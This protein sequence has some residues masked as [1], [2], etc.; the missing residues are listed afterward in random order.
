MAN[1]VQG[2]GIAGG[3][4]YEQGSDDE[5]PGVGGRLTRSE[6]ENKGMPRSGPEEHEDRWLGGLGMPL[7]QHRVYNQTGEQFVS[8]SCLL[9]LLTP[10]GA[11]ECRVKGEQQGVG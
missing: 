5:F 7:V 9:E 10:N 3:R 8:F 11:S 6:V 1:V 2:T 4:D